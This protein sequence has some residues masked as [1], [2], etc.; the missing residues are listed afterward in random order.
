MGVSEHPVD[1]DDHL[2]DS[3][4]WLQISVLV[5]VVLALALGACIGASPWWWLGERLLSYSAIIVVPICVLTVLV[6]KR[7]ILSTICLLAIVAI[8]WP[9][10]RA[11]RLPT[12]VHAD[13]SLQP[14]WTVLALDVR[15][16]HDGPVSDF[17]AA[18]RA[19][20]PDVALLICDDQD[21]LATLESLPE[22]R[23]TLGNL[24]RSTEASPA[25]DEEFG[26]HVLALSTRR[27]HH[28]K[29]ERLAEGAGAGSVATWT[30]PDAA[31]LHVLSA[32]V[33]MEWSA[34]AVAD[35]REVSD[36]MVEAAATVNPVIVV[37]PHAW[38]VASQ[39]WWEVSAVTDLAIPERGLPAVDPASLPDPLA[40]SNNLIAVRG[41]AVHRC[42]AVTLPGAPR[43]AVIM[44]MLPALSPDIAE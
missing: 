24:A 16:W 18:M 40:R 5:A 22:H 30:Q 14:M 34:R 43:R 12:A 44:T 41:W 2:V 26:P 36:W 6:R 19:A 9:W 13:S 8:A 32:F 38:S 28:V 3:P 39:S 29:H 25:Q 31:D 35:Q 42:Q 27:L 23:Y 10:F 15:G 7:R 21:L 4:G 33:P 20:E 1:A 37:M 17:V 11:A